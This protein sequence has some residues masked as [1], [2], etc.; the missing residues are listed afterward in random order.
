MPRLF[1]DG[2]YKKSDHNLHNVFESSAFKKLA[3]AIVVILYN[4]QDSETRPAFAIHIMD[5]DMI[6]T[7]SAYTMK[8]LSLVLATRIQMH[9][10]GTRICSKS[11]AVVKIIRRPNE[12]LDKR[13]YSHRLLLQYIE[14]SIRNGAQEAHWISSHAER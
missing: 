13:D 4:R 8:Y 11:Q 2:A 1:T 3:A 6:M 5:R 7:R 14:A 12:H 10:R 9:S